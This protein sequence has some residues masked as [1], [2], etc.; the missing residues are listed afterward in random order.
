MPGG[1]LIGRIPVEL[2]EQ[3]EKLHELQESGLTMHPS[4]E[5]TAVT[6][7]IDQTERIA[8]TRSEYSAHQEQIMR[9]IRT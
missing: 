8:V 4:A 3:N 1:S 6:A 7:E 5:Q 9:R 2:V